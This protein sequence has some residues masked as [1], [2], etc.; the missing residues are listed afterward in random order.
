MKIKTTRFYRIG[1]GKGDKYHYVDVP[2]GSTLEIVRRTANG[3]VAKVLDGE[4][5]TITGQQNREIYLSVWI[6]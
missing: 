4:Y 5:P 6:E 2:K 1:S 3:I